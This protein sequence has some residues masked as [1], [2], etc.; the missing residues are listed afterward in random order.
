MSYE[1]RDARDDAEI[2]QLLKDIVA[3]NKMEE[4]YAAKIKDK[5]DKEGKSKYSDLLEGLIT[6]NLLADGVILVTKKTLQL[7]EKMFE[8]TVAEDLKS[9]PFKMIGTLIS[10]RNAGEMASQLSS[11]LVTLSGEEYEP[12]FKLMATLQSLSWDLIINSFIYIGDSFDWLKGRDVGEITTAWDFI[13]FHI[14]KFR[15]RYNVYD[16]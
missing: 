3:L 10:S 5:E 1:T 6:G 11:L 4:D 2:I 12:F 7:Y 15:E 16:N 9:A 8:H 14:Q 13:K